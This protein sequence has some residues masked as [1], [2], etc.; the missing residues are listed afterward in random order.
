M[1]AND[2][3]VLR[4]LRLLIVGSLPPPVGGTTVSLAQLVAFV[5]SRGVECQVVD[6]NARGGRLGVLLRALWATLKLTGRIDVASVHF[7]DRAAVSAGPVFWLLLKLR[8]IPMVYRQF[9][10]EFGATYRRLPAWRQWL[11]RRSVLRS[12]AVLLQT[13]AMV[14]EFKDVARRVEWFPTA[15]RN[16]QIFYQGH[17]ARHVSPVLRC[18]YVGHVRHAKGVPAAI[19]AVRRVEGAELTVFGPLFD[20]TEADLTGDRVRYGGVLAPTDVA[21]TMG[22]YDLLLFPTTWPGEGYPGSLVEAALVGLPIVASRWQHLPEMFSDDEVVFIEPGSATALAEALRGLVADPQQLLERSR[23]LRERSRSY[24]ADSV[25]GRFL[26]T[27]ES[28]CGRAPAKRD[29]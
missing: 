10:G 6:T 13:K 26:Q 7:S 17:F 12:N 2:P 25:F 24:E 21:T 27:C 1:A 8:G 18:L 29:D 3:Q 5:N 11:V 9:G 14:E 23:R 16:P 28:V 19:D 15:R 20:V 22:D 4:P